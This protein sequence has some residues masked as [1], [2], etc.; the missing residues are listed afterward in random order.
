MQI[1]AHIISIQLNEFSPAVHPHITSIQIRKQIL[2]V[3]LK[4]LKIIGI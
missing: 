3:L 4:E 2:P 1:I